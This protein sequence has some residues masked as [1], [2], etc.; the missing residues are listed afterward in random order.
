MAVGTTKVTTPR[1]LG[2]AI[3]R[4]ED[5]ALMTGASNFIDDMHVA[6][7]VEVALVRSP[8]AHA[9]IVR[10]DASRAKAL[11]GVVSVLTGR[12]LE[13]VMRPVPCIWTLPDMKAPT[14]RAITVDKAR[15]AGDI[16]A[17]VVASNLAVAEDAAALV[18][19]DYEVL[20][21]VVDQE[22]AMRPGAPLL[23]DDVPAN[24]AFS[25]KLEAG[26]QSVFDTAP[27]RARVRLV[28]QR[29]IPSSMEGRGVLAQWSPATRDLTV[30][31]STQ[32]PHLVRLQLCRVLDLPEHKVRVIA[33][34]VGGGFGAKQNFY[35]EEMLTASLAVRLQRPVKWVEQRREN[36]VAT[37]HGRDHIQ[38]AEIVG[39][40]DGTIAGIR[41]T[42]RA[43][44]GAYFS[45]FA[46]AVPTGLFGLMLSGAYRLPSV[47]CQ[48]YGVLTNT[49]TVDAYRGAGR[50]EAAHLVERLVD[51]FA[52][53]LGMDPVEV[54]RKNFVR[55]GDFP[56]TT[57]TGVTYDSGNYAAALDKALEMA[58]YRELRRQQ[59]EARKAGRLM[60]I[61]VCSFV[62]ICGIA[63]SQ[64]LGSAGGGLGGWESSTVRFSPT[65]K[66]TVLTG[67]SPH[68]QGHETAFAQI[69]ADEFGI[70]MDDV[71]VVHGDTAQVPLGIGT[72]GSRSAAVG[73]SALVVSAR[74]VKDKAV[75]IAAHL[76]EAAPE[77]VEFQDGRF[78]VRGA[79]GRS[80]T[81]GD[82]SIQA[83][84]AHNF[85][86]G[87]EPG[88]EA[89]TFFDPSNFTWP[90]GTH[91]CV[92]E[93]DPESGKVSVL[94]YVAV[95]DCGN[96]INPLIVDGQVHGGITQGLAQ[97]LYEGA[98]YAENGQLLSGSMMDYAI[99]KAEQTPAF[100]TAHTITPS[101]VNPLGVK[102]IGE[103]GTIAASA[104]VV[105]S[106]VDAL[107]HLGVRHLDMPLKSER[108]WRALQ[109]ARASKRG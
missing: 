104:A 6:G 80:K 41:V 69:A 107:A 81:W 87:L 82:V 75:K 91:I 85:P 94:R 60:G 55:P 54:R 11:P 36:F 66:V 95:D 93:V 35:P 90:F 57:V 38:E 49:T 96:L 102:G 37:T 78:Q 109:G 48:V 5:P 12:D 47:S 26:D 30:W 25:W 42:S 70:P 53:E 52:A 74:K 63:P 46:P 3:K 20:P 32:I 83:F 100:E 103:A 45:M 17:A 65:G 56:Y 24:T 18:Q 92:T 77:D 99:P 105:N 27:V 16:V 51:M 97:A 61:G 73:G 29:L 50:P 76:M 28:N 62:E 34:D 13:G 9:R 10:I 106:V 2:S 7:M 88:L 108:V 64:V 86:P 79:P 89:T 8:H 84:L 101:P 1:L 33:P 72:F 4:R 43:N 40:R 71:E 23:H 14:R 98:E 19:V 22:A 31:T 39:Q 44:L 58:G 67:S 15:F 59:A 21:A 68:G